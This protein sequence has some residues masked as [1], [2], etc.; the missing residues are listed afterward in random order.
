MSLPNGLEKQSV[1]Y[2]NGLEKMSYENETA[3][4][5]RDD[6]ERPDTN[7]KETFSSEVEELKPNVTS[8]DLICPQCNCKFEEVEDLNK[9]I[10]SHVRQQKSLRKPT[11]NIFVPKKGDDGLYHCQFCEK[12]IIHR[13]N[14]RRHVRINHLSSGKS[15]T[16]PSPIEI[17][18]KGND[19]QFHCK[20]CEKT[21]RHRSN[22]R[23][24]MKLY[25]F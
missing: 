5:S 14:F 16:K 2:R 24:H 17:P 6:F 25:H 20:H 8:E 1:S 11:E 21:I 23:R 4:C 7:D 13:S 10:K 3:S 15:K 22:L 9:H 12:K 18:Q 19:G